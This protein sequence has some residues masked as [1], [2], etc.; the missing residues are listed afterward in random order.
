[1][2]RA[3]YPGSFDPLTSGHLDV[4]R[5]ATAVFD[6]VWVT[7][8]THPAKQGLLPVKERVALIAVAAADLPTVRVDWSDSLLVEYC[9]RIHAGFIVRGLR[10]PDDFG[11]EWP[12]TQMNRRLAPEIE[13]L[14]LATSPQ[15]SYVSSSLVREL[16]RYGAPL[17]GLV[18]PPVE[19]ALRKRREESS[20]DGQDGS[21]GIGTGQ[22]D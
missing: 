11:Y 10:G 14:F 16:A 2:R 7:V 12:M 18:P 6:E 19:E 1:M 15:W 9:R 17:A 20:Q 3:V 8:F 21:V 5:R 13:T 4:I 22:S